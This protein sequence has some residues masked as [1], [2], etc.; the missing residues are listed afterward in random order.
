MKNLRIL[1]SLVVLSF[2]A[3]QAFAADAPVASKPAAEEHPYKGKLAP[4]LSRAELD[5]LLGHPEKIL[6]IDLRRPDELTAIGGFPIYLSVQ[7][8]N[9]AD[10]LDYIPK[11]RKII[12]VSN[13]AGRAGAAADLLASK[14]FKVVGAVGVQDYEAE[15]GTLFKVAPPVPKKVADAAKPADASKLADA[16]KPADTGKPAEEKKW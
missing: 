5:K 13:H 16:T 4:K 7:A 3:S 8:K 14:G 15:G 6:F 9:L 1:L 11:N 2:I 10:S 12:T